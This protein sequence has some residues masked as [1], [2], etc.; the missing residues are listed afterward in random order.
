MTTLAARAAALANQNGSPAQPAA[1]APQAGP[2][3]AARPVPEALPEVDIPEPPAEGPEQVPVHVA[4]SRVMGEVR[5]IGKNRRVTEGP[6]KF[7][8]R[9]V[10]DA[11]N[12]FGPACR[13]HG[14]L[15]LPVKVQASYRDTKTSTGKATRECTGVVTYRIYGPTGDHIEV[16]AAGESLDSGDK[17][18]AKMQAVAL[19][20][21]LMHGGL[22]PTGDPDPDSRNV[23]R[24]EAAVRSPLSYRDEI[25]HPGTTRQRIVQIRRELHEHR[26]WNA[27]VANESGVEEA[28]GPM[29]DRIGR[30]RF[31]PPAEAPAE[32]APSAAGAVPAYPEGYDPE[33][34][35]V[36][37]PDAGV[38]PDELQ[39]SRP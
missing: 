23:E 18:T 3:V 34:G 24:G 28:V 19:R 20:T 38:M 10:D 39:G 9:G 32:Q 26:I 5:G 17:G 30:Q 7:A 6:A 14:V 1:T 29:A 2:P 4:W 35:V 37:P 15:V 22:V 16:E 12:L 13:L 11:L 8:Y 33:L 36:V 31:A 21:L 27:M 25:L